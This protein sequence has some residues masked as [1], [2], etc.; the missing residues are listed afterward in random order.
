MSYFPAGLLSLY[1]GIFL[2]STTGL[3]AKSIPLDAISI[4][5]LRSVVAILA[6]GAFCWLRGARLRLPS[7]KR[8][9]ELYALGLI[10]GIHW[11]TYFQA[12]Q[13]SSVAVGMLSLFSYPVITVLLEPLFHRQWP[14][15]KDIAA[16]LVL[17][18]GVAIMTLEGWDSNGRPSAALYGALWGTLSALAFAL[19]NTLQKYRFRD[20]PSGTLMFHQ[21]LAVSLLLVLFVDYPRAWAMPTSGW[22]LV[23]ALGVLCSAGAH[24]L[25]T[26]S[27]KHLS[28]KSV[29][30]ISCLQPVLGAL[31]AWLVLGELVSVYVLIGGAVVL[32]VAA[33]ETY[34]NR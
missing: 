34:R 1:L 26:I 7:F 15:A 30:L 3:F 31:L 13:V 19:R 6:L 14:A 16:A 8:L 21:V 33:W 2:M 17:F 28:A 12:M 23:V 29:A 4:T 10:M 18:A 11:I 22:V 5:Q 32:A 27:L 25:L 9:L 24:T 20:T